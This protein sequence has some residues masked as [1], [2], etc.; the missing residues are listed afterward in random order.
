MKKNKPLVIGMFLCLGLLTIISANA[1]AV[2]GLKELHSAG[3]GRLSGIYN[4]KGV[5]IDSQG[6]ILVTGYAS[7]YSTMSYIT[8]KYTNS[9]VQIDSVT[10]N[11]PSE[12][13]PT[14]IAVD[15]HDNIIVTGNTYNGSNYDWYT[16]KYSSRMQVLTSATE[17][18]GN[19]DLSGRIAVD[20]DDNI[21]IA[22]WTNNGTDNDFL[23]VKYNN[24]LVVQSSATYDNGNNEI[25]QGVAVDAEGNIFVNGTR[26]GVGPADNFTIK[27][28]P[29]LEVV[30]SALYFGEHY[31]VAGGVAVDSQGNVI[32]VGK[33]DIP[34]NDGLEF[35]YGYK[36]LKYDNDLQLLES[37][38]FTSGI[39]NPD[40]V[41]GVAV[42]REDNV[43]VVGYK[44]N[45][46]TSVDNDYVTFKYNE[47]LILQSS[48]VYDGGS[49]DHAEAVA[50][51]RNNN[52]V[53]TGMKN[54]SETPYEDDFFTIMYDGSS[55][56]AIVFETGDVKVRGGENGFI[57][58]GKGE[59]AKIS[60][61]ATEAGTVTMKIF[62][63]KGQLV[64]ENEKEMTGE[65]EDYIKWAC[66]NSGGEIVSSGVYI[67]HVTGAGINMKKKIAIVR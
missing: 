41:H 14:G 63:L 43:I 35:D 38:V 42:D 4:A 46:K 54:I 56:G 2:S 51:D 60:F 59:E 8:V 36:I 18:R 64:W 30:T 66:K 37:E 10:Y 12:D 1:G 67:V 61:K 50:V 62:T 39:T 7:Y 22:G 29:A 32:A 24:D 26:Y 13:M 3:F 33:T 9:F 25:P 17:D 58:P 40:A 15:S 19:N 45:T 49:E 48:A 65:G 11:S 52:I 57:D 31:D 44:E 53:V 23:I 21:I 47:F 6:N 55:G 27:Y 16:I 28:N 5:A 34:K 20:K